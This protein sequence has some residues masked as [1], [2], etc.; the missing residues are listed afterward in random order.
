MDDQ[1]HAF[2]QT[3][4]KRQQILAQASTEKMKQEATVRTEC[5]NEATENFNKEL[6][7]LQGYRERTV[8]TIG[9]VTG[10]EREIMRLEDRFYARCMARKATRE[11]LESIKNNFDMQLRNLKTETEAILSDM[12]YLDSKRSRLGEHCSLRVERVLEQNRI[13]QNSLRQAAQL[14]SMALQ[15]SMMTSNASMEGQGQAA[16]RFM[17]VNDVLSP[18][19]WKNISESCGN[20]DANTKPF[21]VPADIFDLFRD[22]NETCSKASG[23][24]TNCIRSTR[25]LSS[26]GQ[27]INNG[28]RQT[29]Q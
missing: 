23:V 6:A 11:A 3:A 28:N 7:R 24:N 22:V 13:N 5:A 27:R 19:G 10:S 20:L 21:E 2:R 26:E 12:D 9:G 29:N 17:S 4:Y 8:S 18:A 14:Q 15:M 16:G 25:S 1:L